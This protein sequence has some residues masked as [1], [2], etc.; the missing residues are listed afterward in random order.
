MKFFKKLTSFIM[1]VVMLFSIFAVSVSAASKSKITKS[2]LS[3]KVGDTAKLKIKNAKGKIKWSSKNKKV[4]TVSKKGKVVAKKE[5]KTTIIAKYKKQKFKCKVTVTAKKYALGTH[6]SN[7]LPG[8]S[9]AVVIHQMWSSSS[10]QLNIKVKKVYKGQ[11]ANEFALKENTSNVVVDGYEWRF[12]IFDFKYISSSKGNEKM[13]IS[14]VIFNDRLYL[15]NGNKVDVKKKAVLSGEYRTNDIFTH[16]PYPGTTSE[17]CF[18]VLI[19]KGTGDLL[20]RVQNG[21]TKASWIKLTDGK[22]SSANNTKP[23]T[24]PMKFYENTPNVPDFAYVAGATLG[25][26]T[27]DVLTSGQVMRN[28]AYVP[29]F[30]TEMIEKYFNTL[31]E[32]G[33]S[34]YTSNVS[35]EGKTQAYFKDSTTIVIVGVVGNYFVISTVK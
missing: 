6:F 2:K 27:E 3:L 4:A 16:N 5:G 9:D 19:P 14:D 23:V 15:T 21:T 28:Y 1:A 30:E 18:G 29:T 12:F 25:T 34:Y 31:V 20:L 10:K 17:V 13:F 7:P 24:K 11:E 8:D 22:N 33:F 32:Y 26:Y 35:S